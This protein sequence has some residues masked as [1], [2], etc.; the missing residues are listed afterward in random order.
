M[1]HGIYIYD[2]LILFKG[3]NIIKDINY[4]LIN[5]KQKNWQCGRKPPPPFKRVN[6]DKKTNIL[7]DEKKDK[8]CFRA[9]ENFLCL[10][11]RMIWYLEVYLR[12]RV[13]KKKG[14]KWKYSGSKSNYRIDTLVEIPLGVLNQI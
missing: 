11:M 3:K 8:V 4:W 13:F 5:F 6:L 1:Y 14:Q 2:D 7:P 9:V 10:D 12:F